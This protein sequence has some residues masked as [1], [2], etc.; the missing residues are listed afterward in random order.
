MTEEL[1][2]PPFKRLDFSGLKHLPTGEK[3]E[4]VKPALSDDHPVL[5]WIVII[6]DLISAFIER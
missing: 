6:G 2:E 1:N 3:W 4:S 5:D